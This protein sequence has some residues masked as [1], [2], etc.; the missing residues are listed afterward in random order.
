[1]LQQNDGLRIDELPGGDHRNRSVELDLY[2]LD[3]L[4]FVCQSA[5]CRYPVARRISADE[6]GDL[7]HYGRGA[8]VEFKKPVEMLDTKTEL[9]FDFFDHPS[10][11]PHLPACRRMLPASFPCRPEEKLEFSIAWS[12]AT[13]CEWI[14]LRPGLL[15]RG[16]LLGSD[17]KLIMEDS[18]VLVCIE[19]TLIEGNTASTGPTLLNGHAEALDNISATSPLGV[20]Q[21][22]YKRRLVDQSNSR[23]RSSRGI[24]SKPGYHRSGPPVLDTSSQ[25]GFM[26]ALT[27]QLGNMPGWCTVGSKASAWSELSMARIR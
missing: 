22:S 7:F 1:M 6:K 10:R 21:R 12:K 9:F 23:S 11:A 4:A 20:F 26:R 14:G 17:D 25:V 8:H 5:A 16:G 27:Y 3:I 15:T 24:P 19:T 18:I 13:C 2:D